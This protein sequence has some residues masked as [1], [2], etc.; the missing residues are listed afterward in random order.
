M[1]QEQKSVIE[2]ELIL[3]NI[4]DVIKLTGWSEAVVRKLFAYEE[5]FPAIKKGKEYLVEYSALKKYFSQR[6]S[7][8]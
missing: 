8:T 4:K 1:T 3:L 6:R 2:R 7:N 5:D